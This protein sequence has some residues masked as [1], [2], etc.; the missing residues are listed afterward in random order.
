MCRQLQHNSGRLSGGV[1]ADYVLELKG[2]AN[3]EP[4]VSTRAARHPERHGGLGWEPPGARTF[5]FGQLEMGKTCS[6][7]PLQ[8]VG[9]MSPVTDP[10]G[11]GGHG[12]STCAVSTPGH[13]HRSIGQIPP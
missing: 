3:D 5:T 9:R 7:T 1:T 13:R 2:S 10:E 12:N 4:K 6:R 11:V 8:R